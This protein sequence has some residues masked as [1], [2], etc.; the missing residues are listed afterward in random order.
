MRV[1]RATKWDWD[2]AKYGPF[3]TI[4]RA[5]YIAE[6]IL[7]TTLFRLYRSMGGD[8]GDVFI[9]DGRNGEYQFNA[10]PGAEIWNRQTSNPG[11]GPA[12]HQE[13]LSGNTNFVYVRIKNRGFE[14]AQ[15]VVVRGYSGDPNSSLS[16]P[17]D[18]TPLSVPQLAVSEGIPAGGSVIAGP[19]T[20]VP[21]FAGAESLLIEVSATGDLSNIDANTFFPCA[22]GPT[23]TSQ[24]I[25]FDNNLARRDVNLV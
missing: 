22:A 9:D 24:L 13:P 16:W 8:S 14:A 3:T 10:T 17:G 5:G 4:D 12:E 23:P 2:G 6:Q 18:W 21:R 15:K 7:S 20:W 1:R 19:L 25:P 11:A